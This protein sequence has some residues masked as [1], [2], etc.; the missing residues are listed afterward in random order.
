MCLF[1]CKQKKAAVI[2]PTGIGKSFIALKLRQ[3]NSD[4]NICQMYPTEYIFNT[5]LEKLKRA[6]KERID[7]LNAIGMVW[8]K[9]HGRVWNYYYEAARAYF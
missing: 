4:K 8:N 3:D 9:K 5:Q 2:H 7:K 6:V 1:F